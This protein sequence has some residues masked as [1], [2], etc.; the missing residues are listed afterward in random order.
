MGTDVPKVPGGSFPVPRVADHTGD[1]GAGLAQ[2]Q[3]Q[4][5]GPGVGGR[6]WDPSLLQLPGEALALPGHIHVLSGFRGVALQGDIAPVWCDGWS[7][8][9]D[10]GAGHGLWGPRDKRTPGQVSGEHHA[11]GFLRRNLTVALASSP[12]D[13]ESTFQIRQT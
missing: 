7:L 6:S 1:A 9:Q 8:G 13:G 3:L 5:H 2:G 12:K 4:S 11:S 10:L